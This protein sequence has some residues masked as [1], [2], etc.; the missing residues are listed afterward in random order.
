MPKKEREKENESGS[1]IA[2]NRK[3][4]HDYQILETIECGIALRG[5]EVKSCRMRSVAMQDSF[6][7]VERNQ[8]FVY[9]MN[10][11]PYSHGNIFN[12][13]PIRPRALML[14][15]KE[16]MRR[17]LGRSAVCRSGNALLFCGAD[18]QRNDDRAR[19]YH[20]RYARRLYLIPNGIRRYLAADDV[21]SGYKAA[22]HRIGL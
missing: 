18:R 14:H 8:I 3:A 1:L 21:P 17:R 5:T 2:Q 15:K 13:A 20:G 19:Q 11:S 6:A 16:I 22:R 10:I 4:R 7:K 12:H 9:N